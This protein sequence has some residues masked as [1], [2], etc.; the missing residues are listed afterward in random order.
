MTGEGRLELTYTST[1]LCNNT[2]NYVTHMQFVCERSASVS[3]ILFALCSTLFL[4][5]KKAPHTWDAL[6][7]SAPADLGLEKQGCQKLKQELDS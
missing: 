1:A 6:S 7:S 3:R 4:E 2:S 5:T